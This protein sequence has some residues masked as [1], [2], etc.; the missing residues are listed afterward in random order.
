VSGERTGYREAME[1]MA[2]QLRDGG[3]ASDKARQ[4]AQDAAKRQDQRERDK[5][6]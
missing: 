1:R 4:T 3:M 2:R 5:G 6:R